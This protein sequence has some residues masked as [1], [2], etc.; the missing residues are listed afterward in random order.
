MRFVPW[1]ATSAQHPRLVEH[2]GRYRPEGRAA[3]GILSSA[4]WPNNPGHVLVIPTQHSENIY[5]LPVDMGGVL[6]AAIRTVALRHQQAR[7]SIR[8][9]A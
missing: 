3:P 5:D 9:L 2:A 6:H 8:R 1:V 4:S 7:Y